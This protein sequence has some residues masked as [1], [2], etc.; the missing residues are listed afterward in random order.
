ME[1]KNTLIF[2]KFESERLYNNY[3]ISLQDQ[4]HGKPKS[5]FEIRQ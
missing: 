4:L 5:F 2:N 1:P 3:M